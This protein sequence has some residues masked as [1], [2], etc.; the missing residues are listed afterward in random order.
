MLSGMAADCCLGCMDRVLTR[1]LL[2]E[3]ERETIE[4]KMEQLVN[5]YHNA[6][7]AAK[8]GKKAQVPNYLLVDQYPHFMDQNPKEKTYHSTSLLGEIYDKVE[9][10]KSV[11]LQLIEIWPLPFFTGVLRSCE[12]KWD[13]HYN[14]YLIEINTVWRSEEVKKSMRPQNEIY[15]EARAIYKLAYEKSCQK[16]MVSYCSFAW[17]VAGEALCQ[18]S[19]VITLPWDLLLV[20]LRDGP[21]NLF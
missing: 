3:E 7:D 5:I 11:K 9:S 18:G 14:Q 1:N 12:D 19:P 17:R 13:Y 6:L 2:G 20:I 16:G 15:E 10:S 8:T 4:T 21:E